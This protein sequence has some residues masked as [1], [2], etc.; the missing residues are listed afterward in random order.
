METRYDE[1]PHAERNQGWFRTS[2]PVEPL[3]LPFLE[4]HDAAARD[5]LESPDADYVDAQTVYQRSSF[6]LQSKNIQSPTKLRKSPPSR[7][8]ATFPI[9]E[10][11]VQL[12][13]LISMVSF[14]V[15]SS[16][17]QR[18]V[19]RLMA[20]YYLNYP[21]TTATTL[22]LVGTLLSMINTKLFV[23][24]I[25]FAINVSLGETDAN[26]IS[27][28][29]F[30]AASSVCSRSFLFGLDRG[31]IRW[32]I[33]S[34]LCFSV[35]AAQTSA[36]TTILTPRPT[37]ISHPDSFTDVDITGP[38]AHGDNLYPPS[39]WEQTSASGAAAARE[40]FSDVPQFLLYSNSVLNGTCHGILPNP[41]ISYHA[42]DWHHMEAI[43]QGFT[44][45][46]NCESTSESDK[47]LRSTQ[48]TTMAFGKKFTEI[49]ICC[50]C[51][52]FEADKDDPPIFILGT[53]N[54]TNYAVLT[55][56]PTD[57]NRDFT[58]VYIQGSAQ[59]LQNVNVTCTVRP[60]ILS[61]NVTYNNDGFVTLEPTVNRSASLDL[62]AWLYKDA[63][64]T[65]LDH[66][67]CAQTV[68]S[69]AILDVF[70][71]I[72]AEYNSTHPSPLAD[73]RV[74]NNLLAN[75]VRGVFEHA[76]TALRQVALRDKTS[77]RQ[78]VGLT[79]YEQ[80][81]VWGQDPQ[82]KLIILI[83]PSAIMITTL[84]IILFYLYRA[85]NLS[86]DHAASFDPMNTLHVVAACSSGNVQTVV[87]PGYD[88]NMEAFSKDVKVRLLTEERGDAAGFHIYRRN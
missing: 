7:Q 78:S 77:T 27:L 20:H 5:A 28:Y 86:L 61:V 18:T 2:L 59:S 82:L 41:N 62:T 54:M 12:I 21:Q 73:Q 70:N 47:A 29:S 6:E 24:A 53:P 56:C 88:E 16:T 87:F 1:I 36:W 46:V 84:F 74:V 67:Y 19:P 65:L 30:Y 85:R 66:F 13:I 48:N 39:V 8:S 57:A 64:S 44:V 76:A 23:N 31:R 32:T 34:L 4:Q 80:V 58:T 37:L 49:T 43:Q 9:T 26:G 3:S 69:N 11:V 71:Q 14:V 81:I 60:Q 25:C 83:S 42:S 79:T 17:A 10:L 38:F 63:S 45:D 68:A 52:S 55:L 22:T 72:Y 75:Y 51:T 33:A 15:W 50:N 40:A 35:F